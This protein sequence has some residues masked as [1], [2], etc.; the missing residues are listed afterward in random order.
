MS[1][2]A[3]MNEPDLV[4]EIYEQIAALPPERQLRVLEFVWMNAA[5]HAR[6]AHATTP[7]AFAAER[8]R[9]V[10]VLERMATIVRADE[11]G[12]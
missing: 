8:D 12:V 7:G 9:Q 10:A 3:N 1:D 5:S 4:A 11:S 2:V 6:T